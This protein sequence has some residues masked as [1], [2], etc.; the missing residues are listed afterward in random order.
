MRAL[1]KGLV[2]RR[3]DTVYLLQ[4]Q[5]AFK[6]WPIWFALTNVKNIAGSPQNAPLGNIKFLLPDIE[7]RIENAMIRAVPVIRAASNRRS[8]RLE[9]YS[10]E[11]AALQPL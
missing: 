8:G 7:T 5:A 11:P 2:V 10:V 4:I 6:N 9:Q 3:P 1:L